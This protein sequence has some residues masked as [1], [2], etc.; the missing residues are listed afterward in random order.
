MAGRPG[1]RVEIVNNVLP[2]NV[3]AEIN[4]TARN[5]VE[6]TVDDLTCIEWLARHGLIRNTRH[7]NTCG[8]PN[9]FQRSSGVHFVDGYVWACRTCRRQTNLR[10][11]SFFQGSHVSLRQLVDVI[12]WWSIGSSTTET[13]RQANIGSWSTIVDWFN[14]IRDICAFCLIDHP[15]PLGGPGHVVEIDESKFMHRKY[16]R[17]VYREGHWVLGMVERGTNN[18][19]MVVVEDRSAETLLPIIQQHVLPGTR[20]ITDGW[21]AYNRLPN[22]DVV[23]HTLHFVDPHDPTLHTN[24][25]EGNWGNCKAKFRAKHGTSDALFTSHLQEYMWRRNFGDNAF[26]NVLY[27]IRHYYP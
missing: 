3:L 15:I 21:R 11:D 19:V 23:N 10:A 22:H 4:F 12:Y 6:A 16:H 20:I 26:G 14:F 8:T 1:A 25:V 7:C 2:A 17:G 24:T 27:W 13:K 18:C 9:G 5:L